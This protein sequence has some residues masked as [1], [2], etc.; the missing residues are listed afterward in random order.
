MVHEI[1]FSTSLPILVICFI[2]IIAIM[3]GMECCLFMVLISNTLMISDVEHIF[4]CLLAIHIFSLQKMSILFFYLLKKPF[5]FILVYS[6][7][8]NNIV[9]V[10]GKKQRDSVI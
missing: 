5:Y 9:I 8:T 6:Q 10:S 3:T 7:L 1:F 4:I 2:L